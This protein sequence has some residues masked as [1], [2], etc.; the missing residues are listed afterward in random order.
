MVLTIPDPNPNSTDNL[1][2]RMKVH[3]AKVKGTCPSPCY[4]RPEETPYGDGGTIVY[5]A[6]PSASIRATSCGEAHQ[7]F[8]GYEEVTRSPYVHN[9]MFAFAGCSTSWHGV[10]SALPRRTIFF[11][12]VYDQTR[13]RGKTAPL[14]A[15]CPASQTW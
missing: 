5:R 9:S 10:A 14:Q 7:T 11:F 12:V 4:A 8:R 13:A 1:A 3:E 2:R 15:P 6:T